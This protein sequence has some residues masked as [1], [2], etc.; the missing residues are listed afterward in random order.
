M[1]GSSVHDDIGMEIQDALKSWHRLLES[2]A[3][4]IVTSDAVFKGLDDN[5]ARNF[6]GLGE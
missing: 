6:L 5:I 4:A 2:D 3:N 1:S